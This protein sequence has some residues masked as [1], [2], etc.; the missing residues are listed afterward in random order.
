[1]E[2]ADLKTGKRVRATWDEHSIKGTIQYVDWPTI[3]QHHL[4][5]VQVLLDTPPDKNST[6]R[7]YRFSVLD[8]RPVR[9]GRKKKNGQKRTS[10]G[11]GHDTH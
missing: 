2:K 6:G 8:L 1:M 10:K 4:R 11:K 7:T 3:F 9:K 5:P